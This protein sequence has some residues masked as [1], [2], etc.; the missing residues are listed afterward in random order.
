MR[1]LLPVMR[2]GAKMSKFHDL[3]DNSDPTLYTMQETCQ[4]TGLSYDTLKYYC[5]EGLV[6]DARRDENNRRIF[7]EAEIDWIAELAFLKNIGFSLAE[8]H[9][10]QE[11]YA[12]GMQKINERQKMLALRQE[13]LE[14]E[15]RDLA[16][17]IGSIRDKQLYLD[18]LQARG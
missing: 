4:K 17:K 13:A 7:S 2:K 3:E 5:K 8:M 18:E 14:N 9:K 1:E 12:G 11:L 10:Y 15:R 6:P 16:A